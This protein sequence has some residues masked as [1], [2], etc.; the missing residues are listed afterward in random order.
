MSGL[1]RL[2]LTCQDAINCNLLGPTLPIMSVGLLQQD[3]FLY[4]CQVCQGDE[5]TCGFK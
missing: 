4:P 1:P 2:H 3:V 5:K